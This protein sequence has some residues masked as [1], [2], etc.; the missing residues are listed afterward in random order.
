MKMID[1]ERP[2]TTCD[3]A[4]GGW[5]AGDPGTVENGHW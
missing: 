2:T 3:L 1:S 5:P 4:L